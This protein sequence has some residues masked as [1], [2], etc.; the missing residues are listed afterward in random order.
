MNFSSQ[1]NQSQRDVQNMN[2]GLPQ[3]HYLPQSFFGPNFGGGAQ[4]TS[5]RLS[6]Q[7]W[8]SS[9]VQTVRNTLQVCHELQDLG[10]DANV[11]DRIVAIVENTLRRDIPGLEPADGERLVEDI[12]GADQIRSAF[13]LLRQFGVDIEG[14][15][16][17]DQ[18]AADD[19]SQQAQKRQSKK[20]SA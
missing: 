4:G 10:I 5:T 17:F 13:A 2:G 3:G 1:S 19:M 11:T 6:S 9:Y 20:Q 12:S 15:F 14:N 18:A 16:D 8:L 7:Q